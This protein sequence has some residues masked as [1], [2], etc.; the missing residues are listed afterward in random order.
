M[1]RLKIRANMGTPEREDFRDVVYFGSLSQR[2]LAGFLNC[3]V[4]DIENAAEQAGIKP[5]E[6]LLKEKKRNYY[7]IESI[8]LLLAQLKDIAGNDRPWLSGLDLDD[9]NNIEV[10]LPSGATVKYTSS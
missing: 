6:H 2:V 4:E 10:R 3:D 9:K 8:P 7:S 5:D 1:A